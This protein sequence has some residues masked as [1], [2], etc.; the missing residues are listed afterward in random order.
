MSD[1]APKP[2][3]LNASQEDAIAFNLCSLHGFDPDFVKTQR[4]FALAVISEYERANPRLAPTA[5]VEAGGSERE[6]EKRLKQIAEAIEFGSGNGIRFREEG[7]V[8]LASDIRTI[9]AALKAT[10][11]QDGA[12]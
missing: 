8:T 12:T 9:I 10:V 4:D 5:S 11:A 6:A 1:G 3:P 7:A 2:G